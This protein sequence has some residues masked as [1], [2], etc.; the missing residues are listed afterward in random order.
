MKE[1]PILFSASMVRAILSGRK[2]QTRREVK[3]CGLLESTG[4]QG[5]RPIPIACPHG[6][7]GDRLWVRETWQ[8]APVK[9]CDCPQGS[10]AQPCDDWIE[11]IGCRSNRTEVIYRED[12]ATAAKWRSPIHMPRWASRITLE[13]TDIRVERVQDISEADAMA[14]GV[15]F[16][17]ITDPLTGEIDRDATEAFE[18]LWESIHGS[19]SWDMNPYVWVI[20]FR[21][22]S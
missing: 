1:R 9:Y 16:G 15:E 3:R 13:I 7:P 20:E 22:V 18:V 17:N 4:G 11:G 12:E 5:M 2:T 10:E 21:R 14:E 8:Y 19:G 6:R